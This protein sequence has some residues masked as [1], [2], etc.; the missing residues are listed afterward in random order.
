MKHLLTVILGLAV[1]VA[2]V[3]GC[4]GVHRYDSRL[5]LADSLMRPDPDSALA[6]VKAVDRNSL[7][8]EG[9]RAYR[10]L[11]LTQARYRC[12]VT[13][14]SDSD[15]NRALAYYRTHSGEREKLTRALIYK[16]AVMDE[17]GHPD[18]AMLYY[19][20]AEATAAPDDYFNLGYSNLRIAELY[21]SFYSNDSAV[22]SRMKK[23]TG[24][25]K[26]IKDTSYLITTIGTQGGYPKIIGK[27]SSLI[28]LQRA[29]DLAKKINSPMGY[30][31]QSK[32]AGV[33]FYEGNYSKAKE[34]A[35][36][37]IKNGADEC[38]ET[39]FYYYAA[40][41][42]IRLAC[43]DSARYVSSI[44]P[45]PMFPLDSMNHFRLAAEL[46]AAEHRHHDHAIYL[47]KSKDINDRIFT[48]SLESNI[49]NVE[50]KFDADK[51]NKEYKKSIFNS[52]FYISLVIILA[53]LLISFR[54]AK[55]ILKKRISAYQKDFDSARAEIENT[56]RLYE[57]KIAESELSIAKQKALLDEK[58]KRIKTVTQENDKLLSQQT[59]VKGQVSRIVRNRLAAINEIYQDIR[60]KT[61]VCAPYKKSVS[62][63]SLLKDLNDKKQ[64]SI[65][66]PRE[67]FWKNLKIS[68]DDEYHGL[69]TFVEKKYPFL[70]TKEYQLFLLLSAK[71]SPQI[72]K[73]C[74]DYSNPTT[75]SN[76]KRKLIKDIMGHDMKFEDFIQDY[77]DGKLD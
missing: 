13:A 45:A 50:I 44:I 22:V 49:G 4:G 55:R 32:L 31:Y 10:D 42:F 29:I 68:I 75:V 67:S 48:K 43:L 71:I 47:A 35:M 24:F 26:A 61:S 34:L 58:D 65:I 41:S 54:I 64:L 72:I 60:V 38:D 21:Q 36:D 39:Q 62:L 25:F 8:T 1:L 30:R 20:Q 5:V 74:M 3:T 19:K 56:I 12:Y 52:F 16:G 6:I 17:L 23:A 69:A 2:A 53:V 28:Y 11:L 70:T 14:T 33:Y 46:A 37:V 51:L 7:V 73:L 77:L 76:Y 57:A 63:I 27:D 18:S 9:D 40:R 66:T 59:I 15:I